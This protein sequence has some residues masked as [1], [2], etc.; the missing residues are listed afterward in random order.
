MNKWRHHTFQ[1]CHK[2]IE[3]MTVACYEVP[4]IYVCTI[5]N[6]GSPSRP[7]VTNVTVFKHIVVADRALRIVSATRDVVLQHAPAS[8]NAMLQPSA[9]VVVSLWPVATNDDMLQDVSAVDDALMTNESGESVCRRIDD[10]DSMQLTI[11][12]LMAHYDLWVWKRKI[13]ANFNYPC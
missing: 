4:L 11:A 5:K 6:L 10:N 2:P 8:A 12:Q 13:L 3:L 1:T 9:A 7:V